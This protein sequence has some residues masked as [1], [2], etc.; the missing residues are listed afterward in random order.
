MFLSTTFPN[1]FYSTLPTFYKHLPTILFVFYPILRIFQAFP[2][3]SFFYWA[4]KK[5]PYNHDTRSSKNH[6]K[7]KINLFLIYHKFLTILNAD[8]NQKSGKFRIRTNILQKIIFHKK[9]E[10]YWRKHTI[11][12]EIPHELAIILL[13]ILVKLLVT[14]IYPLNNFWFVKFL[15]NL[16]IGNSIVFLFKKI[17]YTLSSSKF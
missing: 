4:K 7:P 15:N 8:F 16:F 11:F 3:K 5:K 17:N 2:E 1:W 9:V 13:K 10:K 12:V 6:I 14:F